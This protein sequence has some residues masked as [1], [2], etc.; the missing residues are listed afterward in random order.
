MDEIDRHKEQ[1]RTQ[2]EPQQQNKPAARSRNETTQVSS[3]GNQNRN[4][5]EA[6]AMPTKRWTGP[7]WVTAIATVMIFL[8]TAVYTY[9]AR[10][11]WQEMK[12]SGS[13]TNAI[14]LAAKAQ[15]QQAEAQTKKM[16][17]SVAKTDELIRQATAQATAT[18]NLAAQAKRS[19]DAANRSLDEV[20]S[21]FSREQR[22]WVFVNNC[23]LS[24][25][26]GENVKVATKCS[27]VNSGKSPA[28]NLLPQS[29][30][31]VRPAGDPEPPMGDLPPRGK[32]ISRSILPS[33]AGTGIGIGYGTLTIDADPVVL[34]KPLIDAYTN[35][36]LM[37]YVHLKLSY[38]DPFGGYHWTTVCAF[39]KYGMALNEW[40]HC[41]EGNGIDLDDEK[42]PN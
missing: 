19:A 24:S 35:K 38:S 9:Y 34:N 31:L 33:S 12:S 39:H 28:I 30:L 42:K 6:N 11:Q 17:E 40:M 23:V 20:R 21:N 1:D 29:L 7:D 15:S 16:G 27:L 8:T 26:P 18:N 10:K 13:D 36:Q 4:S 41:A 5:K 22:P 25:E 14:A 3:N 32:I 37:F 2:K